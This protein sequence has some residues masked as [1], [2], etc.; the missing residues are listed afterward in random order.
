MPPIKRSELTNKKTAGKGAQQVSTPAAQPKPLLDHA[1]TPSVARLGEIRVVPINTVKPYWRN[2]RRVTEDAVN[3][4]RTSIESYGYQQPIVVDTDLV[5]IVGHTRYAA[6]RRLNATHIAVMVATTLSP[7]KVK[8]YRLVDNKVG[9]LSSWDYTSLMEELSGLDA[10]LVAQFF[11]EVGA[12][13]NGFEDAETMNREWDKVVTGVG[14]TCPSCFHS[15]EVEVTRDALMRGLINAPV[16]A[17]E[18]TA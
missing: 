18:A 3:Q 13:P 15:W 9:E 12:M 16:K 17:Q 10:Q 14:F 2:P 5:I 4:V 11:P 8:Q 6:F 7:E 1:I